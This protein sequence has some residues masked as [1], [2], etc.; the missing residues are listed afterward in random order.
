M[1][2]FTRTS[3]GLET[4]AVAR[5]PSHTCG[6]LATRDAQKR[7]ASFTHGGEKRAVAAAAKNA[8][9]EQG[10]KHPIMNFEF[11]PGASHVPAVQGLKLYRFSSLELP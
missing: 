8:L 7:M 4:A 10:F 1:E 3:G 11:F 9:C 2:L 6:W 5:F